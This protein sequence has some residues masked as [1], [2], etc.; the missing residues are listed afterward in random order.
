M[1]SEY[2]DTKNFSRAMGLC[3]LFLV[4]CVCIMAFTIVVAIVYDNFSTPSFIVGMA[5]GG[6]GIGITIALIILNGVGKANAPKDPRLYLGLGIATAVLL[7]SAFPLLVYGIVEG[8]SALSDDIDQ[9]S[10]G[11]PAGVIA[12]SMHIAMLGCLGLIAGLLWIV[13]V[14]G[15]KNITIGSKYIKEH[16]TTATVAAR[17]PV[18]ASPGTQFCASC[19]EPIPGD[20]KFCKKC[21]KPVS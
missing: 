4:L 18:Q 12:L 7:M 16:P 17:A 21:G 20:S 2:S 5:A 11:N 3:V 19:G 15:V 13:V 8:S 6:G 1:G 14:A 10:H 9:M